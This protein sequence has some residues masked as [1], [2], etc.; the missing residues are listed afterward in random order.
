MVVVQRVSDVFENP[1]SG[2]EVDRAQI[3]IGEGDPLEESLPE[4][5]VIQLVTINFL[6][7]AVELFQS[8]IQI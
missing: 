2:D 5:Q 3:K 7:V 4:G 6:F 1:S 8:L